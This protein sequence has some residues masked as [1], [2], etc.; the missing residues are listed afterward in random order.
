M[1]SFPKFAAKAAWRNL[2]CARCL[3]PLWAEPSSTPQLCFSCRAEVEAEERYQLMVHGM[4]PASAAAWLLG[5]FRKPLSVEE[6][7]E[8][9]AILGDAVHEPA[10]AAAAMEAAAPVAPRVKVRMLVLTLTH[11]S[12]GAPLISA[13]LQDE[14]FPVNVEMVEGTLASWRLA[15]DEDRWLR[16]E[17]GARQGNPLSTEQAAFVESFNPAFRDRVLAAMYPGALLC[18]DI[19]A[20]RGQKR[21]G[22]LFLH[23]VV[24]AYSEYAFG[25]LYHTRQPEAAVA[26]LHNLALPFFKHRGLQTLAVI[27]ADVPECWPVKPNPY[28]RYLDLLGIGEE[29]ALQ[30]GAPTTGLMERFVNDFK[31]DFLD[32]NE[33]LL[34]DV[35]LTTLRTKLDNWLE[36][37]NGQRMIRGFPNYGASPTDRVQQY[38][39]GYDQASA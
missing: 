24:D 6:L 19:L 14:G 34:S 18:Q 28:Q 3:K 4:Q 32:R 1:E 10:G 15:T 11:P 31:T 20:L 7:A 27:A 23:A 30:T 25:F 35:R 12:W 17:E 5:D 38:L 16:L 26:V 33:A 37:Y 29:P 8:A 2:P 13:V 9:L 22:G 36:N 21:D 39:D